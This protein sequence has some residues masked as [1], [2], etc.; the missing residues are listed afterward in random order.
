MKAVQ[1]PL[2]LVASDSAPVRLY[3]GADALSL[4]GETSEAMRDEIAAWEVVSRST[5]FS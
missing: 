2:K 5:D 4:V 3:L 1:A